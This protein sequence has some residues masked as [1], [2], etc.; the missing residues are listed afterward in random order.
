MMRRI[1]I[2]A[3]CLSL[4]ACGNKQRLHPPANAALPPKPAMAPAAPTADELLKQPA[5][6]RPGRSDEL[7]TKS[8]ARPDDPF[9]QPPK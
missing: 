2:A 6:E 8:Q 5:A 1:A 3:L 9:D 7:L 4:A